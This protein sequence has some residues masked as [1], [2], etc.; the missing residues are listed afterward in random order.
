MLEH[1]IAGRSVFVFPHAFDAAE[2]IELMADPGWPENPQLLAKA[3][4]SQEL[5]DHYGGIFKAKMSG[6]PAE[7]IAGWYPYITF[8]RAK[9]PIGRHQDRIRDIGIVPFTPVERDDVTHR[10]LVYLTAPDEST[11]LSHRAG[12]IFYGKY[13]DFLQV[14]AT[15]GTLVVFDG[16]L[17]HAGAPQLKTFEKHTISLWAIGDLRT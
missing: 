14:D 5:A 2:C 6:A 12:T 15:L 7:K 16:E 11:P 17:E 8:G 13:P 3:K 9:H 1:T 10:A 4:E